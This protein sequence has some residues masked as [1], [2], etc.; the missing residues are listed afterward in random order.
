[1]PGAEREAY[2]PEAEGNPLFGQET[3]TH[4]FP[5]PRSER[6]VSCPDLMKRSLRFQPVD[7]CFQRI[8]QGAQGL[9]RLRISRYLCD[10]TPK[11]GS[12]AK[13]LHI[14]HAHRSPLSIRA[15]AAATGPVKRD[16]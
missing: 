13:S 5:V 1:M 6:R 10:L 2:R 15:E 12:L 3:V 8:R 16:G 11:F 4:S 7:A 9:R 14:V